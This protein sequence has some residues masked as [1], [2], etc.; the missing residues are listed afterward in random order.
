MYILCRKKVTL[1]KEYN[2]FNLNFLVRAGSGAGGAVIRTYVSTEPEPKV[3]S[4]A[5][6]HGLKQIRTNRE[7]ATNVTGLPKVEIPISLSSSSVRVEKV[8]RSIS[9]RRKMSVYLARPWLLSSCGRSS[10]GSPRIFCW[11]CCWWCCCC[12]CCCCCI[13]ESNAVDCPNQSLL[14]AISLAWRA[15]F[16]SAIFS[17]KRKKGRVHQVQKESYYI[18]STPIFNFL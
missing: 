8:G 15:R 10:R 7:K 1:A 6:K 17:L 9:W 5:P 4:T 12:W 13:S 3:V 11:C 18:V 14:E 16:C 2:S